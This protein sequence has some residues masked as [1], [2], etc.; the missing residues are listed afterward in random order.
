M[1]KRLCMF[2]AMVMAVTLVACGTPSSAGSTASESGAQSAA[3]SSASDRPYWVKGEDEVTG[4]INVY[5]TMEETQQQTLQEM[6][7]K[8]YPKCK[9]EF[10]SDSVGTL[11]TRLKSEANAPV[12][13]VLIGGLFEADGDKYHDVLQPYTAVNDSEQKYHDKSGYY[14]LYDVQ[15]MCLIVNKD[16]CKDLGIEVKGY[17]DLLQPQL[18]GKIILAEP[19]VSSSAYRQLQTILATMGKK[20]DDDAGWDY[21]KQ[22]MAQCNG[23]STT[24]S[25]EVYNDVIN[26]EY[27][28]GL[29]YESTVQAMIK[30][31]ATNCECVYMKEGN[32]AMAGGAGIV[33]GAP[34][35][36][37][38]EAMMNLLASNEFQDV[39]SQ[40]SGGRGTN[41]LCANSGLP[42][43]DT[44]GLVDL[45]FSYLAANKNAL[46]DHWATLWKNAK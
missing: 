11:V 23:I 21:I 10:Q 22:L 13:D 1:K 18:K 3:A 32:T 4:T 29:S 24:S 7:E 39:R 31:G 15:L 34:N 17:Q 30:D 37:A 5:T 8:Y 25:S 44:L 27:V 33:K 2:L 36:A 41:S 35:K 38:A 46:M 19:S 6:W 12:A 45:D 26:G 28:V 20:F 40:E 43:E 14:T 16:L 42:K 9:I